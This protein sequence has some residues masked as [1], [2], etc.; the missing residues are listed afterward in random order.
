MA[1]GIKA[2]TQT[3][4]A[5]FGDD[6]SKGFDNM[7]QDDLALPFVR[8]LG[9][10]SPQ[11]TEGDA[12]YIEGAKPGMI[13][14]TVTHELYDGKKGIKVFLVT[15]KRIIQNGRTRGEGNV[16]P[17]ATHLPNSAIIQTGKREGSKD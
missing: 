12:K 14:N 15:T 8:I 6:V 11:V 4:L 5:L 1:N 9:Q 2:K 16:A 7:T 10:L 17:V 3:S 13:Y